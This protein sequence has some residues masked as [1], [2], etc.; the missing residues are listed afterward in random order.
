MNL[1]TY[2]ES[3]KKTISVSSTSKLED[4]IVHYLGIVGEVG[5]VVSELKKKIR[6]GEGYTS[7]KEQLKEE[8]G[9]VLWYISTIAT[10]NE[11]DLGEIATGN[12]MKIKDRFLE[13]S[14]ENFEN[15]DKK[16]PDNERFPEEF[17]ITFE[18]QQVKDKIVLQLL[19]DDQTKLGD[20]LADNSYIN[21]GY[22]YHD[23]FHL[24]YVAFLGWSP[25][26]R[27]LMGLKRKSEETTDEIED[28]ARAII[29]EELV[30]LFVYS[31]AKKHS[32]FKYSKSVDT[33]I[34]KTIKQLVHGIE[35]KDC[36]LKQWEM[37]I[38]R[39]Y[40]VFEQLQENR[41]G[42]VIVS[43]KNRNLIYVGKH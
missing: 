25:V 1:S 11:L 13:T 16:Y 40:E 27:K 21:D 18:E 22:R 9:D 17:E 36:P 5:S 2:Q 30:S 26:M 31:E 38:V 32:L 7:F 41:G 33:K 20:T 19:L 43:I 28:G 37:A 6:D 15:Y 3:A 14:L 34:L 29:I 24:G 4:E 23:I 39:S 8:L 42:R 12:L 10:L 35:I